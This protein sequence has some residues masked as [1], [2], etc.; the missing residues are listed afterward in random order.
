ML[1]RLG[2]GGR[3]VIGVASS[4]TGEG[5]RAHAWLEVNDEVIVGGDTEA[6]SDFVRLTQLGPP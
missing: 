6:L 1:H 3:V 2:Y 4:K 5:F